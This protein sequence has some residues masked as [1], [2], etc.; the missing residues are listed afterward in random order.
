MTPM[1]LLH[2]L[3][4]KYAAPEHLRSG[5]WLRQPGNTSGLIS[6]CLRMGHRFETLNTFPLGSLTGAERRVKFGVVQF[7]A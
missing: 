4:L 2:I 6:F 5:V 3:N 1:V 7:K